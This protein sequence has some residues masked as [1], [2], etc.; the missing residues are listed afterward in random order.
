MMILV[1]TC[2][3]FLLTKYW[4]FLK[5]TM[6]GMPDGDSDGNTLELLCWVL[7]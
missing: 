5:E 2:W 1:A 3:D 6:M 7:S 4:V